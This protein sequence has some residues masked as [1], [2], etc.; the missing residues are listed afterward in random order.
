MSLEKSLW[1]V[2]G[3]AKKK[4]NFLEQASFWKWSLQ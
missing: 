4:T 2:F 1:L 3:K